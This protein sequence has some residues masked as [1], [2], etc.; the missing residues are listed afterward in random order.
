MVWLA[1]RERANDAFSGRFLRTNRFSCLASRGRI[2]V[3]RNIPSLTGIRGV[4]AFMVVLLHVP[5][6]DM[7]G[8]S[9]GVPFIRNGIYGV[10]LFFLLSGF[11]LCHVHVGDFTDITGEGLK[12][13]AVLRFFRVYP[14]HAIVLLCIAA[15]VVTHPA[16]VVWV[17]T[18]P[19]QRDA[20]TLGAFLQ[21]LALLNRVGLPSFGEY[22]WPSWSLSSEVVGYI[23]FPFLVWGVQRVKSLALLVGLIAGLLI[24]F[25]VTVM[26]GHTSITRMLFC[27]PAGVALSCA[28]RTAGQR[29]PWAPVLTAICASEALVALSVDPLA[30][31]SVFGFAGVIAGLA[32]SDE[33]LVSG[34][35]T[36]GPILFLG[37]ISFSL[38]LTHLVVQMVIIWVLWDGHIVTADPI[39]AGCLLVVASIVVAMLAYQVIEGPSHQYGRL[40]AGRSTQPATGFVA[41]TESLAKPA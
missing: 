2:R 30:P 35:L 36:S 20:F 24:G 3:N 28:V 32:L 40:F 22:N 18:I 26:A 21:T 29:P 1:S 37:K 6:R 23:A 27:F 15:W 38:Y 31:F 19:N 12:R 8:L 13:F 5:L 34:F 16:F 25:V 39:Y 11:I 33:G 7:F 41:E 4:A 10:D 9:T 14:L 17:R